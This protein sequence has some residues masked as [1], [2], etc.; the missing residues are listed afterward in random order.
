MM[1]ILF[2]IAAIIGSLGW[3]V[4]AI[5]LGLTLITWARRCHPMNPS[6]R[7]PQLPGVR[8]KD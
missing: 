6:F 7:P 1:S 3:L 5:C 8:Q 4:L 2:G